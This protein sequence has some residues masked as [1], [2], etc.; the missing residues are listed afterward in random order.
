MDVRERSAAT[1]QKEPPN[2]RKRLTYGVV[3]LLGAGQDKER[4]SN[5]RD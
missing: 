2:E 5:E 4:Q 3:Q 1:F